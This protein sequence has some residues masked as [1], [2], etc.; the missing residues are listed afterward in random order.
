MTTR[1][2]FAPTSRFLARTA[3]PIEYDPLAECPLWLRFL[4]EVFARDAEV[5]QLSQQMFGYLITTDTSHQK[6]FYLRGRPRSGKGTKMRIIDA[7]IGANNI[8]NAS[9]QALADKFGLEETLGKSL[10]KITEANTDNVQNLSETCSKLNAI[11]GED[12]VSVQRKNKTAINGRLPLRIIIA[13]NQYPNFREHSA[14]MAMRLL[15][16]PFDVTF[17]G[18]EDFDLTNKLL[19]ELPGMLDWAIEGLEDL[20]AEGRFIEPAASKRA[21]REILNSGDSVRAFVYADCDVIGEMDVL[22]DGGAPF[23]VE[24]EELHRRYL[25]WCQ[26]NGVKQPL[27]YPVFCKNLKTQFPTLQE[28]KAGSDGERSRVFEGI[29]LRDFTPT[30]LTIAY[31]LDPE[32][33]DLGF[34][35]DDRR[36]ILINAKGEPVEHLPGADDFTE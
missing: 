32:L 27:S 18:R 30:Y 7:L 8:S 2:T 21:K 9:I 25:L 19:A 13:G 24:K 3:L 11:S 22:D 17:Y 1:K 35:A 10:L 26:R 36:A 33:L 23:T 6:I 5:I 12:P 20:R 15:V 14:A 34:R 29:R 28:V 16:L 31:R 4:D